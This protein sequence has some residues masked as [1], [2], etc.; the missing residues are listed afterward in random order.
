MVKT[1]EELFDQFKGGPK[2]SGKRDSM[3]LVL[4]VKGFRKLFAKACPLPQSYQVT[5]K[6]LGDTME[7][8]GDSFQEKGFEFALRRNI[9]AGGD[10]CGRSFI[11]GSLLEATGAT[12]PVSWVEQCNALK[13][14]DNIAL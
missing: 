14:V 12:A 1:S 11:L 7:T 13:H 10:N 4:S 5:L 6:I 2:D 8:L 9:M 3:C